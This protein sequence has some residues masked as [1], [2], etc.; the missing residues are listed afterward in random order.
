MTVDAESSRP[1]ILTLDHDTN[2]HP[3]YTKREIENTSTEKIPLSHK[4]LLM[5]K[6]I[7]RRYP[8]APYRIHRS[9]HSLSILVYFS[10]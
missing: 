3:T 8:L 6:V 7:S 9:E 1:V 4:L 2:L 10:Y 5:V